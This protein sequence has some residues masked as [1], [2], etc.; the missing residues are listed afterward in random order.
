M[1]TVS[2][3]TPD[4][5]DS[6]IGNLDNKINGLNNYT[7]VNLNDEDLDSIRTPGRYSQP[8][9]SNHMLQRNYPVEDTRSIMYVAR[10]NESS[11]SQ[12]CQIFIDLFTGATYLRYYISSWSQWI[13]CIDKVSNTITNI[14]D[15]NLDDLTRPGKYTQI[16]A[17]SATP[18]RNY[19]LKERCLVEVF[20]INSNTA[21]Q[22]AQR[23][24]FL[25]SGKVFIRMYISSWSEWT[26]SLNDSTPDRVDGSGW[27]GVEKSGVVYLYFTSWNGQDFTLPDKWA[28]SEKYF[29]VHNNDTLSSNKVVINNKVHLDSTESNQTYFG[30]FSYLL[31]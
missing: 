30:N 25:S 13:N 4:K 12:V 8:I 17:N 14:G 6:L 9:A 23:I 20:N 27:Y 19:P 3:Y 22:I 26:D 18:A 31:E 29:A 2:G 28:T 5:I 15:L 1:A 11:G 7:V 24:T 21:K 10:M 16:F